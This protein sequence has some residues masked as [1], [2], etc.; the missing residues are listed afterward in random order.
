M[1]IQLYIISGRCIFNYISSGHRRESAS[2]KFYDTQ[3]TI[4][5]PLRISLSRVV[6]LLAATYLYTVIPFNPY[7]S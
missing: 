7:L 1:Y 4:G 2:F 3:S 6:A 5:P